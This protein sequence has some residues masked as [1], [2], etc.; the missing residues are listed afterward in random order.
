[1][2]VFVAV[3]QGVIDMA[4]ERNKLQKFEASFLN[5]D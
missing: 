5:R 2:N 1:M 3:K 4:R